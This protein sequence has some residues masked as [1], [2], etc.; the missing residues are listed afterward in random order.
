MPLCSH[1]GREVSEGVSF[2]PECGERL[3]KGFTPEEKQEYIQEL[4][5]SIEEEKKAK[6]QQK[7]V[8]DKRAA[9]KQIRFKVVL[10]IL[11]ALAIVVGIVAGVTG[12]R[13]PIEPAVL[14][15]DEATY[16]PYVEGIMET[17]QE[18]IENLNF[19]E[20]LNSPEQPNVINLLYDLSFQVYAVNPPANLSDF[21]A[22]YETACAK[23]V[24]GA[25]DLFIAWASWKQ[26]AH[27]EALAPLQEAGDYLMADYASIVLLELR[28]KYPELTGALNTSEDA[29]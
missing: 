22:S 5:A 14:P 7:Q 9:R 13:E 23:T 16:R 20:A 15:M 8:G 12:E 24:R 3:K 28:L 4:K 19:T 10:A 27:Q 11:G 29:Y 21:H 25:Q 6:E 17:Q 2:C 1:C 26:G 18:L